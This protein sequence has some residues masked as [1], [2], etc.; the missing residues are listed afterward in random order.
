MFKRIYSI[1]VCMTLY[2]P[3]SVGGIY[4]GLLPSVC[5]F[6]HPVH[7]HKSRRK[8]LRNFKFDV[9]IPCW[10]CICEHHIRAERS[11]SEISN[12]QHFVDN[13]QNR[14]SWRPSL[15]GAGGGYC[16]QRADERLGDPPPK[17]DPGAF[18]GQRQGWK[19]PKRTLWQCHEVRLSP[20]SPGR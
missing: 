16:R 8:D 2:G 1:S 13:R 19:T 18:I 12:W 9:N 20:Q 4:Y 15:P 3:P 5:L 14:I 6:I 11:V 17:V 7:T 10:T